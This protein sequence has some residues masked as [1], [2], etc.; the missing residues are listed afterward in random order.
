MSGDPPIEI[1][2][3]KE[4]KMCFPQVTTARVILLWHNCSTENY[5]ISSVLYAQQYLLVRFASGVFIG[6]H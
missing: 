6:F 2:F 5:G 1:A 4:L 3:F